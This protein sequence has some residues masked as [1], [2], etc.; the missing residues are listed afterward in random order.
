MGESIDHLEEAKRLLHEARLLSNPIHEQHIAAIAHTAALIAQVEATLAKTVEL[1]RIAVALEAAQVDVARCGH[2][3]TGLCM[4]CVI[5]N[6][7]MRPR[8]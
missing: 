6:D 4:S 2:G 3:V 5:Q 1:K 7:L 8:P